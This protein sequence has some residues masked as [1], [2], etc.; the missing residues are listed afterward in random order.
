MT[1]NLILFATRN[2]KIFFR[3]RTAVI[4]SMFGALA[5]VALYFLFLG[6]SLTASYSDIPHA[7]QIIDSW[8]MAGLMAIVPV[9]ATL[10]ALGVMIQDKING[11]IR[12][13]TVSPMKRYEIA[14]GYVLSTFFVGMIL[15]F[16][17]LALAELYIVSNGGSFLTAVQF[18][19]VIGII[20]LSVISASAIMF[21][22]ALFITSNNAYSAVSTVVGTLIG[23]LTGVFIPIGTF[24]S[25]VATVT[26]L[27]PASHSASL[28]RQVM[29]EGPM[30]AMS[31]MPPDEILQF[32]LDMGVRFQFGNYL[33]TAEMSILILVATAAVFFVLALLKLSMKSK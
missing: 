4:F 2:V 9:T 27:V 19:K 28:F 6:N 3:D 23:F 33:V 22:V 17:V 14:G 1:S 25:T 5:V 15:S 20:L 24:P 21:F 7:R 32:E 8:A 29:L 12:D 31:G 13:L 18:A 30:E 10:G 11:A 26:K 16:L